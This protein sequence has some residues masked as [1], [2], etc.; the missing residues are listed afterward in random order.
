[1]VCNETHPLK[2]QLGDIVKALKS[3]PIAEFVDSEEEYF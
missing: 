2:A 3:H 1:M